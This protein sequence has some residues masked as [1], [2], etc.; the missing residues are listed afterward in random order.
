M[1]QSSRNDLS[2]SG[3]NQSSS[4]ASQWEGSIGSP[5][6]IDNPTFDAGSE[7]QDGG[8]DKGMIA[9]AS[10]KLLSSAEHQK[11]AGATFM[12]DM[13]GAV[14]RAA[15]EFE[16]Q[17]PQAATYIRYAA[18]QM[19]SISESVRQ[20]DVSQLVSDLQSF[21]RRQPTAFLGATFLAGFAA[22]RFLKSSSSASSQSAAAMRAPR[23]GDEFDDFDQ[24]RDGGNVT[25]RQNEWPSPLSNP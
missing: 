13:A 21:A 19:D 16:T 9:K 20:R 12:A 11:E 1:A 22:V 4:G 3:T 24:G 8:S 7:S 18:D 15:G 23:Y 10:D 6:N 14:R 2:S 17:I 25:A 5:K